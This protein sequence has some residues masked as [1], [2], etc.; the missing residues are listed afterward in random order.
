MKKIDLAES[1]MKCYQHEIG[2]YI[3]IHLLQKRI[4]APLKVMC[5]RAWMRACVCMYVCVTVHAP[6]CVWDRTN[7]GPV[8]V[9]N[10]SLR[11]HDH[12]RV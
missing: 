4:H 5:V 3:E 7:G 10:I 1:K 8:H 9:I 11:P 2:M 12:A 6:V